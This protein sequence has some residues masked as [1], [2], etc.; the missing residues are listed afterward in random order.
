MSLSLPELQ[1]PHLESN[2][3]EDVI[4]EQE[5]LDRSSSQV[6]IPLESSLPNVHLTYGVGPVPLD[7]GKVFFFDIDNCLYKRSSKIHDLMQIYIHRYFK[8]TLQINDKEAWDLHHKYYQQ[9]GLSMEGLVRHNNIDAME[10]NSKVDDSLPLEKILRPNRRLR[11]MILRLKKSGKVDRL[12]LFT[13]AYKNHALR[14]IYLLGLGDLFD[15]LTYCEYDKIPILCKPMKPIFDKAL[16]AAGCKSTKNAY[17]VDDSALN[18]K[19]AREL[20]FAKVIHYVETDDDMEKLDETHKANTVI[21]RDILELE[22]VC[23]ELF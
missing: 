8:D 1:D 12:W 6:N 7:D 21:I 5:V 20:G 10:Y 22:K 3:I 14:V 9:Y 17:F 13:N 16:L 2:F 18:V 23:S 15:G 19:A 11:E 4:S